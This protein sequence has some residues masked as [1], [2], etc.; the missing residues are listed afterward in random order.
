[1]PDTKK[2]FWDRN[3][4][5]AL[6]GT[7]ATAQVFGLA[8][9]SVNSPVHD[10]LQ[11]IAG[12]RRGFMLKAGTHIKMLLPNSD[13]N[14]DHMVF[15]TEKDLIIN[16]AE[17]RL[18]TGVA[19]EAGRDYYIYLCFQPATDTVKVP[20]ADI[21]VSLNSTFPMGYDGNTSRKIGGFHTLCLGAGTL[22]N[23]TIDGTPHPAS[24]FQTADIIPN[25]IWCLT[26]RSSGQF[27]EGTAYVDL[28]DE[29]HFIY[30]Q[31]GIGLNTRSI[32]GGTVTKSRTQVQHLDDLLR[33]GYRL[34][35]DASFMISADGSNAQTNIQGSADPITTGGHVDTAGRR[36]IS[37]YFLEDMCGTYWFWLQDLGFNGQTGWTTVPY[38][39]GQTYGVPYALLS[40]GDWRLAAYCGPRCRTC[41]YGRLSVYAYFAAR[42]RAPSR[43]R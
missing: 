6:A 12:A 10:F 27:Q 39:Q 16:Y 2:L 36:M 31:S 30:A 8:H 35:D 24:G 43:K 38:A 41:D 13:G 11:P 5:L 20:W 40:G 18:D 26:H 32:F 28:D 3:E 14:F 23:N 34:E 15:G 33:V 9:P 7:G 19:F 1:M 25:S 17:E 29:W 22:P 37:K 42:G 4:T 21:R